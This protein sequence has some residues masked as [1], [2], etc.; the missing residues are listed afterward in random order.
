MSWRPACTT[1]STSGSA[2]TRAS[3]A[4][5]RRS[6]QRVD[7]LDPQAGGAVGDR[8]LHQAQQRAVAALA[9]ELGVERQLPAALRLR[10]DLGD[11]GVVGASRAGWASRGWSRHRRAA[12]ARLSPSRARRQAQREAR[13]GTGGF[14]STV[15][16]LE[17]PAHAR[18][19][20]APD[21]QAQAE[22]A[23]PAGGRAALEALEDPLAL[24]R[25][26]AGA[27]VAHAQLRPPP[28][29][30]ATSTSTLE[31]AGA[32]RSA[33]SSRMRTIRAT[34]PGS[35]CAQQG[36]AG[37]WTLELAPR[38]LGARQL[39]LGGDGAGTARRAR[40]ARCAARPR[41]RGGSGRAGRRRGARAAA[42][43]PARS[44]R[45]RARPRGRAA[46]RA[47]RPRAARASRRARRAAC[48]ARARRWPRTRGGRPPGGAA[49][50]ACPRTRASARRSRRGRGPRA[51]D[52]P[53][54]RGARARGWRRAGAPG[55]AAASSSGRSRA[56]ARP[57]GRRRPPPGRRSARRAPRRRRSPGAWSAPRHSGRPDD[58]D[59][60]GERSARR[61]RSFAHAGP[62]RCAARGAPAP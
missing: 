11:R 33:L 61:R 34:A 22:A 23:V 41:R 4:P 46:R 29:A 59:P 40:P 35:A 9:H 24:G 42:T 51:A 52:R 44:S 31:S 45:A 32:T 47:G 56:A 7:Q 15:E 62:C 25:R 12:L 10:G 54:A 30:A 53:P 49:A 14:E 5:S 50:P 39:E 17:R 13:A 43:A 28:S 21:R 18:G 36:R 19:E 1:T 2:S 57:A 37:G 48:A 6:S 55:G 27:V 20:L 58:L 60:L 38:L 26:D 8:E 3:G 16:Q